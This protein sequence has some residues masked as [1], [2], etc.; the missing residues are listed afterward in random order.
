MEAGDEP[1]KTLPPILPSV[2]GPSPNQDQIQYATDRA[3]LLLG[4][5]RKGEV[6]DP[7][8]Y[9]AAVAAV[10]SDY[11]Q[12]IIKRT[13]DPRTGI[14]SHSK[15]L[16]T[17]SEIKETCE[18]EMWPIRREQERVRLAEERKR[19]LGEPVDRSSRKTYE[20]LKAEAGPDWGLAEA[21]QID[22]KLKTQRLAKMSEANQ[23]FF[24]RECR[25]A[26]IN[27]GS[28]VSPSLLKIIREKE[29]NDQ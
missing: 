3:K 6:D 23:R 25:V 12:E 4:C 20:E 22:E 24:E 18:A 13:T 28:G 7:D 8:T 1:F 10:L 26:G 19:L 14:A 16:P 11:P 2:L 9:A 21:K 29:I 27:P 5:F 17:I 15:W